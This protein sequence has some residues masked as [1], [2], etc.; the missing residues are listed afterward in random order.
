MPKSKD[1]V[2]LS[3]PNQLAVEILEGIRQDSVDDC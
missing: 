3:S 2:S 1:A